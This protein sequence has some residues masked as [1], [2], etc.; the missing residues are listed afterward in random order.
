MKV[1]VVNDERI[2]RVS[3]GDDV[4]VFETAVEGSEALARKSFPQDARDGLDF[5]GYL[6]NWQHP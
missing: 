1:M 2:K 5:F 4:A 6:A 3:L